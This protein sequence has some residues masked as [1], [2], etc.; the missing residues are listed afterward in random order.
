MKWLWVLLILSWVA[1]KSN[2]QNFANRL[3]IIT[4]DNDSQQIVYCLT[5][6]SFE[7]ELQEYPDTLSQVF[8]LLGK[9][10]NRLKKY[11]RS[12][13]SYENSLEIL[14]S[15]KDYNRVTKSRTEYLLARVLLR[16]GREEV[17]TVL[18][19]KINDEN[20]T[21]KYGLLSLLQLGQVAV[22]HEQ[23]ELAL[24]YYKRCRYSYDS[25]DPYSLAKDIAQL[26][27]VVYYE[28]GENE[29]AIEELSALVEDREIWD[30][31]YD[32]DQALILEELAFNHIALNE[33][34]SALK[35]LKKANTLYRID[36]PENHEDFAR[37]LHNQSIVYFR[38]DKH[39]ESISILYKVLAIHIQNEDI[40]GIGDS[41]CNL[42]ES[43]FQLNELDSAYYYSQLALSEWTDNDQFDLNYEDLVDA[44]DLSELVIHLRDRIDFDTTS[45]QVDSYL[46][47]DSLVTHIF[48]KQHFT[49]GTEY[50][51]EFASDLYDEA[52]DHAVKCNEVE[53]ALFFSEKS[54]GKTS[55]LQERFVQI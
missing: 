45:C 25:E 24:N 10:Y 16:S 38:L 53:K 37:N 33:N 34:E 39:R 44:Y 36:D 19:E 26:I 11:R 49:S 18:L 30:E 1:S 3:N 42:S 47:I 31:L 15:I 8:H 12:I 32:Y 35:N 6:L 2:A 5:D 41:Y 4:S 14:D 28:Q 48:S 27:A 13:D 7:T 55:I 9:Y 17:A 29:L 46:L 22:S 21:S 40:E 54:N 23:Y 43:Y 50:W 51:M 52:I 20:P